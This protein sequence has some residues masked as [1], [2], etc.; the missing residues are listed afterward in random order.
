MCLDNRPP[1]L[2]AEVPGSN[3]TPGT[4][5]PTLPNNPS[6]PA[7]QRQTRAEKRTHP[8]LTDATLDRAISL[9]G[10]GRVVDPLGVGPASDS[11]PLRRMVSATHVYTSGRC[12]DVADVVRR[13]D[14]DENEQGQYHYP[15]C[16]SYP[17]R[18]TR[19][20]FG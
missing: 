10:L 16:S 15:L 17:Y 7:A 5:Q 20:L 3:P 13:R 12:I 2:G 18:R 11:L 9:A 1:V 6:A 8:Y 4:R 14:R 19:P